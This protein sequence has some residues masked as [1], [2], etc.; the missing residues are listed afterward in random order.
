ML[1]KYFYYVIS[2]FWS[3]TQQGPSQDFRTV[4]ADI[5]MHSKKTADEMDFCI[6]IKGTKLDFLKLGGCKISLS[7]N[8]WVQ[9][10]PLHSH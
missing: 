6:K 3:R 9:L 5:W 2:Q 8:L 10:Y 7:Q 1:T 4:G